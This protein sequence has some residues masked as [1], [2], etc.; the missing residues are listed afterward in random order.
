MTTAER[1]AV[2]SEAMSL[3]HE[4]RMEQKTEPR[5]GGNPHLE[6]TWGQ[7]RRYSVLEE[8]W[9]SLFLNKMLK[10]VSEP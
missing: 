7:T 8:N 3:A 10:V 2:L 5:E 6:A 4:H 1:A 9:S